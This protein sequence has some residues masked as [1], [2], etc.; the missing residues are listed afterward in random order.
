MEQSITDKF[1]K[2]VLSSEEKT[3][4]ALEESDVA[5]GI[6]ECNK[7]L[8]G[9][10]FGEK[11]ASFTGIK[12]TMA[13]IWQ[14]REAFSVR[15][16]G[17]DAF[18]F[19]FRNKDDKEKVLKGKPWSFDNQYLI[20]KEWNEERYAQV[21]YFHTV[22][23]WIQIWNLPLHWI[24]IE[25]GFRIGR[26]FGSVLDVN[27]PEMGSSYGRFVKAR[28]E[29]N[30]NKPL[31]WG[32]FINLGDAKVWVDFKYEKFLGFCFYCG[33][34]GHYEKGCD[35]RKNDLQKQEIHT[36]QY[37]EWLKATKWWMGNKV[38]NQQNH[39]GKKNDLLPNKS[40]LH[41]TEV[42]WSKMEGVDTV[43]KEAWNKDVQ[44]TSLIQ[45]QR[46]IRNCRMALLDWKAGSKSN[47]LIQI[48]SCKSTLDKLRA[49]GGSRDW[50]VWATQKNK[51]KDAYYKEES[52][53]RQKA[54]NQWL[55]EGDKNTKFFHACT[56]QRR[57]QNCIEKLI[58]ANG[59]ECTTKEEITEEISGF[60]S[61]LFKSSS[62]LS[63]DDM[64]IGLTKVISA[65]TNHTLIRP[66]VEGAVAEWSESL[67]PELQQ[68][69]AAKTWEN[70]NLVTK[71]V[72]PVQNEVG[73]HLVEVTGLGGL[74]TEDNNTRVGAWCSFRDYV[75]RN[76]TTYY[77]SETHKEWI[78]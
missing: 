26:L 77:F 16:V 27:I 19:V 8:L 12:N 49:D 70:S 21:Q 45:T 51:L 36:S 66:V 13:I 7:S 22:E 61:A 30:L 74:L 63:S 62:P 6:Q 41:T 33:H 23:L 58:K 42:G 48:E 25:T 28:V 56:M 34:V 32:T 38:S 60:Y 55:L 5:F 18:Q 3:G 40:D 43:I 47:S 1:M 52:F 31:I 15:E 37:R 59:L 69:H 2:F 17:V 65:E 57:N 39:A 11:K 24:S 29:V 4:I 35:I 72:V 9:R 71:A 53:W 54:R 10:I 68:N 20:L 44:G 14:T 64:L 50:Q 76:G 78:D 75:N 67:K 46:Q 73:L